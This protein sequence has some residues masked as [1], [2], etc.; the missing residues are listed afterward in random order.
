MKIDLQGWMPPN[1]PGTALRT[2]QEYQLKLLKEF[3]RVCEKHNLT[4]YVA[5]GTLLGAARHEGFIPWD[6]D[7]D[8]WMPAEDYLK[9]REVCKTS[10]G[11][12]YYLQCHSE[13]PCNYIP[14]QRIGLKNTTSLPYEYADIHADW[15]ICIDVFGLI[16]I[17]AADDAAGRKLFD[18][19]V[20][21]LSTLSK[22]YV[23][24]HDAKKLSGLSKL[25]HLYRASGSDQANIQKWLKAEQDVLKGEGYAHSGV[26]T[27]TFLDPNY[28]LPTAAFE[29]ELRYLPFED[30]MVPVPANYEAVLVEAYGADWMEL[31]PEEKRFWHSGGGSDEVKVS[32]DEPWTKFLK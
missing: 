16:P 13:N 17:P 11:E 1:Q 25:Y 21:K 27:D 6:D 26:M 29:G 14:W 2:Y 9:F 3:A 7:I 10:L 22:K 8:V 4:W 5:W 23:Y 32:L 24:A 20:K 15:G 12:E 28:A 31:P 30:M 19:R 18:R